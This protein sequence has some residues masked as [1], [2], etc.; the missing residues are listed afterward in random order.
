MISLL[1]ISYHAILL[2]IHAAFWFGFP[3]QIAIE[4]FGSEEIAIEDIHA[5][6]G[7]ENSWA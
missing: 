1:A 5:L 4:L 6:N 3:P 7:S 2:N